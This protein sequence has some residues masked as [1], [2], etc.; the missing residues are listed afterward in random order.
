M[1]TSIKV[2]LKSFLLKSFLLLLLFFTTLV[3][4]IITSE[5]GNKLTYLY[6]G[7]I[8]SQK[9]HF[10]VKVL[11]LNFHDYPEFTGELLLADEYKIYIYGI[12]SF[13]TLDLQYAVTSNCIKSNICS[14]EDDVFVG[15]KIYGKFRNFTIEGEGQILD[16]TLVLN[17]VKKR[18]N[19]E[20]V[21][22]ALNDV[23]TTKFFTALDQKP[24]LKGKS[25]IHLH[26]D[27]LGKNNIQGQLTFHAK[28]NNYSDINSTVTLDTKVDIHNKKYTF[29]INMTMPSVIVQIREGIYDQKIH[30]GMANYSLDIKELADIKHI[31][32][33][34]TIGPFYATGNFVL[35][36]KIKMQGFSESF[37]G[38]L[39]ITYEKKKFHFDLKDVPFNTLMQRLKQHPLL[40]AKM[41]GSID[42]DLLKREMHTKVKLKGVKFL[43]KELNELVEEKFG[44]DLKQEVFP[45]SNFEASFKKNVLSSSLKIANDTN[46]FI[47]KDTDLN[48]KEHS[49]DTYIDFQIQGHNIVGKLYARN[50]GYARHTLDTYLNFDGLV[51]KHYKVKLNGPL[52]RKWINMDYEISATR[53]PSHLVTI[54][55]DI[56][57]TGHLYGPYTRLYIRGDGSM[58]DG[59]VKFDTLKVYNEL[60]NLNIKM[61]NIH[62]NKLYTLM[63][64]AGLPHGKATLKAEFKYLSKENKKGKLHY[65]LKDA[66]YKTLPLALS[67]DININKTLH[68]F[69]SHINLNHAK[70][71]IEKG[72]YD[73]HTKKTHALF[74]LNI[75]NLEQIEA[76][77]GNTYH[78]PF[79]AKGKINYNNALKIRGLSKSFGGLTDFLYQ[80]DIL[81]VDFKDASFESIIQMLDYPNYLEAHTNGS[82]NYDFKKE[83]LLINTKLDNARFLKSDFVEKAYD[84]AGINLLYE[85]F[86]A[87]ELAI[88]YQHNIITGGMKLSNLKNHIYLTNMHINT[89]QKTVNAYFD[90]L[91]QNKEFTGKIYGSLDDPKINL[92]MQKLIQ[93]EMD[94]Q[95]DSIGGKAPRK[96]MEGLPMGSTAKDIVTGTAGSFVDI[97][98]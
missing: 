86:D 66:H 97:F 19:F 73:E 60:K 84:K 71:N 1:L 85:T 90:V 37:G 28:D 26:F 82:I 41:V 2:F 38:I 6:I 21:N 67:T 92:D 4:V 17:A 35:D 45:N 76:L 78:G 34:D 91:I 15:G 49:I 74:T 57:I 52:S 96:L 69:S 89:K 56:N 93:H 63:G 48:A 83:L 30:Y 31:T 70:I 27:T 3:V 87:S 9:A 61:T 43:Q 55:D 62:A 40:D 65:T 29:D 58:L 88:K 51:E 79:H 50:D 44:H 80:D 42:Y 13:S 22:L 59:E 20:N 23:N 33:V 10:D 98:F 77:I 46:H 32:K 16:G 53:L 64:L 68:T 39:N 75:Q 12:L 8:I 95:I 14:I 81:Y 25:N 18:R 94:K 5:T 47:F 11:S 7:D 72:T 24:L 36:K 54:E